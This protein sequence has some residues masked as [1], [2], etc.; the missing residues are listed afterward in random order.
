MSSESL[1]Y[2]SKRVDSQ[3]KIGA[4]IGLIG[5]CVCICTCTR[6]IAERRAKSLEP[7]LHPYPCP[8]RAQPIRVRSQKL[9]NLLAA[10]GREGGA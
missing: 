9:S 8:M 7:P 6:R 3:E 1:C 4:L 2:E 5:V 10:G